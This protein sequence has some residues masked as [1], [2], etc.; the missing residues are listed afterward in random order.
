MSM[1]IGHWKKKCQSLL[2]ERHELRKRLREL[3]RDYEKL[4]QANIRMILFAKEKGWE[5]P[6]GR[7]LKEKYGFHHYTI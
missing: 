1:T 6:D 7:E 2:Y 4:I 5:F 3:E